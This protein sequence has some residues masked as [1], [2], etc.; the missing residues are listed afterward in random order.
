MLAD[1]KLGELSDWDDDLV[2]E[3]LQELSLVLDFDAE[4]TGFDVAEIDLRIENLESKGEGKTDA[5]DVLPYGVLSK[6]PVTRV[7]DLWLIGEHRLLCG[8]ALEASSYDVL[9]TSDR[10]DMNLSDLP[11]NV[12]IEG[13]VSG[14]GKVRHRDFAMGSGEMTPTE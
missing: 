4:L 11:Y 13:N 9:L 5:A 10:A 1:N 8:N 14:L 6:Q 3:H 2:G 12:R 7:G